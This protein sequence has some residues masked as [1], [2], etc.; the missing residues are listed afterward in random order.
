M[1]TNF[2]LLLF[3]FTPVSLF[4]Q[5]NFNIGVRAGL[6]YAN[7]E[8]IQ[9]PEVLLNNEYLFGFHFGVLTKAKLS[10]KVYVA[11]EFL[12]NKKGFSTQNGEESYNINYLNIPI[13]FEL[14]PISK[15]A[16]QIGPEIGYTLYASSNINGERDYNMLDVWDYALGV[17][18]FDFALGGGVNYLLNDKI[19]IGVRYFHGLSSL[20]EIDNIPLT[21]EQGNITSEVDFKQ[22][23]RTYQFSLSYFIW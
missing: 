13:M 21:D 9:S 6:N 20:F 14:H 17:N 16:L 19:A 4:A 15:L 10:D 1:K 11:P 8:V 3:F 23:N 22:Q 7:S 5:S 12:F 18:R 2:I